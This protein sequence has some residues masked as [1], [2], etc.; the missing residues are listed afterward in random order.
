MAE[1]MGVMF[2]VETLWDPRNI[3]LDV[4]RWPSG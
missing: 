2:G 4:A 1:W 3:V